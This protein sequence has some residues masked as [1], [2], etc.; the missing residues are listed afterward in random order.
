ME[1]TIPEQIKQCE[2]IIENG[3]CYH[4][5]SISCD[6][7]CIFNPHKKDVIHRGCRSSDSVLLAKA[8]L[9]QL[10]GENMDII[11]LSIE[12][13]FNLNEGSEI[14]L[15]NK[16]YNVSNIEVYAGGI[17]FEAEEKEQ[18]KEIEFVVGGVYEN[19]EC[20]TLALIG[21]GDKFNILWIYNDKMSTIHY[22]V[23]DVWDDNEKDM[24]LWLIGHDFKYTGRTLA[25]IIN[26]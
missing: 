13:L 20:E 14:E 23:C 16:K 5:E 6:D 1:L 12:N 24:R 11:N 4:V 10:R 26:K 8:K 17:K 25:D 3:G 22:N 15:N 21:H 7:N 18:E 19:D 9:K 2:D